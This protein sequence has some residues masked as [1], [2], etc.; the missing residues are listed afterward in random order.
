MQF[1]LK[2]WCRGVI[3]VIR[4]IMKL[5]K[6][7]LF[8][9]HPPHIPS[10]VPP[11]PTKEKKERKGERDKKKAVDQLHPCTWKTFPSIALHAQEN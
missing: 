10:C 6:E 4:E 7:F 9:F 1:T 11:P 5:H 8:L 3:L 2:R